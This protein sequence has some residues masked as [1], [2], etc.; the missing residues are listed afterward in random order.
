MLLY[1]CVRFHENISNGFQLSE[2]ILVHGRNGYFQ[3]LL[4]SKGCN[5][6]GRL[7]TAM[8][9]V[10]CTL[11]HDALPL[12]EISRK[13]LKWFSTYRADMSTWWKWLYSM[14]KGQ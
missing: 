11:S 1:I 5:S 9:L 6:I 7:T 13:Y 10:F 2:R 12:C 3:Y 14:F 8:V 4:C